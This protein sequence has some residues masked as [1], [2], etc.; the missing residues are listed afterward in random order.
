MP[1]VMLFIS[2]RIKALLLLTQLK[3]S[4]LREQ[5]STNSVRSVSYL[6]ATSFILIITAI[7][8][9][10]RRSSKVKRP[11]L[12]RKKDSY[13]SWLTIGSC[14][15]TTDVLTQYNSGFHCRRQNAGLGWRLISA[16]KA[17]PD[18]SNSATSRQT[19]SSMRSTRLKKA[20]CASSFITPWEKRST[21]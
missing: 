3:A 15:P 20:A 21:T 9:M 5:L 12:S 16:P 14:Y 19:S 1:W 10:A 13:R 6:S 4:Q 8:S 11:K 18:N 17:H 7:I 2:S